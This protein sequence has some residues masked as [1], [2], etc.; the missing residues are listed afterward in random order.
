MRG[1]CKVEA[2]SSFTIRRITR[3]LMRVPAMAANGSSLQI[4]ENPTSQQV[5]ENASS[6]ANG[7]F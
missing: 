6:E 7:S 5:L 2:E 4:L 1:K 3:G